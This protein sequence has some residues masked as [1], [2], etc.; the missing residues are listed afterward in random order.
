MSKSICI[1]IVFSV[2]CCCL[3]AGNPLQEKLP[4]PNQI[5]VI[6]SG[7][8]SNNPLLYPEKSKPYALKPITPQ[9]GG[10]N[11]AAGG[12]D[13]FG[14]TYKD[15]NESGGPA[16]NWEDISLT[17]N[18][19]SFVGGSDDGLSDAISIGFSFSYYGNTYTTFKVSS[20]GF[21]TVG[22]DNTDNAYNN[23][24]LPN[25]S[26]PFNILAPFWDD[27]ISNNVRYE[28]LPGRTVISWLNSTRWN[29]GSSTYT[30]QV[31]IYN[32]GK[33]RFNYNQ[34]G[35]TLTSC[36]VGMQNYNGTDGLQVIWNDFYLSNSLCVEFQYPQHMFLTSPNGGE[37]WTA[38]TQ[39]YITWTYAAD[40]VCVLSYSTDNGLNWI[41]IDQGNDMSPLSSPYLWTVPSISTSTQ[42]LI[43]IANC[44]VSESDISDNVFTIT[45]IHLTSPNGGE[46]WTAGTQH[47]ITWTAP[48]D[49]VAYLDY[50]VDN[51]V[52][53]TEIDYGGAPPTGLTSPYS[54]TI[55]SISTSTQCLI[56]IANYGGSESD[57]SDNVF[58][59]TGMQL[60]SPNGGENWT[61][62][63]QHNITWTAPCDPVAYL[64]Y[65]VDNGVSWTEID[66]GGAP[67]TGL[68]SPY[69][70]TIPSISTSTQCLIRI[71]NYGG[72]ESDI[73]DN[74]F[75]I[76]GMHLTS[77]DG[78]ENWTAGTQHNITWTAPGDHVCNLAYSTDNGSNWTNIEQTNDLIPLSSPYLWTVPGISTSIQC[79]IR[80]ASYGGTEVDISDNVFTITGMHLTSPDGG[81]NWT[82]GT[83]HNITWTAPFDPVCYLAY[84]TDI[85][86]S[87][88]I[89]EETNDLN[90]LS[91]P[92][93]WTLPWIS[94]S[95]QCLIRIASYG[96]T[97]S[98]ISDNVFTITGMQLTSP[99]GGE[100]WTAGTQHNIIW[101]APCDPVAYLDYSVDNGMSWTEID[102]GG[103]PPTGLTS[104][105]LWTIPGFIASNQCLI[106][107]A[108]YGGTETDICNN[109]FTISA[110]PTISLTYPNGGETIYVTSSQ[111]INWNVSNGAV[112]NRIELTINGGT[113][114]ATLIE[115]PT[116]LTPTWT[117]TVGNTPSSNC[118]IR[119][120]NTDRSVYN[121]P[122]N[123][124]TILP[125]PLYLSYPN[126]GDL[127]YA[128][129]QIQINFSNSLPQ[130]TVLSYSTDN[131]AGWTY[132]TTTTQGTS[133]L[134]WTVPDVQSDQCLI[135]VAGAID[136]SLKDVSDTPFSIWNTGIKVLTPNGG[137]TWEAGTQH[138]LRY[139]LADTSRTLLLIHLYYSYDNGVNW[140]NY[141]GDIWNLPGIQT[142]DWFVPNIP[143]TTVKYKITMGELSD[144]SDNFFTI[145]PPSLPLI[146]ITAPNG[147]ETLTPGS[148]VDITWSHRLHEDC[149]VLALSYSTNNGTSWTQI[150]TSVQLYDTH[151]LWTVPNVQSENCLIKLEINQSCLNYLDVSDAVFT[152]TNNPFIS[153]T[154][155]NGGETLYASSWRNITWNTYNGAVVSRI[156][157]T[158]DGGTNWTN[159]LESTS[160]IVSPC[161]WC[162]DNTPS[163]NC[164][165]RLSNTYRTV[166][167]VSDSPFTIAPKPLHVISPD[168][169]ELYYAGQ[170]ITIQFSNALAMGTTV[171]YSVNSGSSFTLIDNVG[172]G[173]SQLLWTVPNVQCD[174]CFIRVGDAIDAS[175]YDDS[176]APFSIWNTG[177]K[178]LTPSGGEQW[179]AGTVQ[180][181]S[182]LSAEPNIYTVE[183]FYSLDDG[184]TWTYTAG[185]IDISFRGIFTGITLVPNT[186]SST[187]MVKAVDPRFGSSTCSNYITILPPSLPLVT[188]TYP[189]GGEIF[190]P[191]SQIDIIWTHHLIGLHSVLNLYYS[192]NNGTTWTQIATNI[193]QTA[194]HY[195]WTVPDIQSDNCLIKL[196]AANDPY[197]ND[198]SDAAFSI[199]N[200]GVRVL[201]PNGG[202]SWEAG[203]IQ[204]V[205]YFMATLD[206]Q[207]HLV[208][209]SYSFDGGT[210]FA[211]LIDDLG[212]QGPNELPTWIVPDTPTTMGKLKVTLG[213]F[214]DASDN[215]FT[216][217]PSTLPLITIT[218]PNGGEVLTP[219]SPVNIAW[220]HNL[221]TIID[222]LNLYYSTNNGVN[223]TYIDNVLKNSSPYVWTVPNVNSGQCLVKAEV[224]AEKSICDVSDSVF[225]IGT[226]TPPDAPTDLSIAIDN[227]T[228]DVTLTWT[229]ATGN[230]TG[231]K[232]YRSIDPTFPPESTDVIDITTPSQTSYID[233][234]AAGNVYRYF[235]RITAVK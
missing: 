210:S 31:I 43:L 60:T 143:C 160:P 51:G 126:G 229:A 64:D 223:W 49:P 42:C 103:A 151:Y 19:V 71:A 201:S 114:W 214:S 58:T 124:F 217:V 47:N 165:I 235:Y 129:Q 37:D 233:I 159:I 232:L 231:Y 40:P 119:L 62:G 216:I 111:D 50:S 115:S 26:A 2:L 82:A 208:Q 1:F 70:W 28:Y 187:V 213:E 205:Q 184:L 146:T 17:G 135:R 68:T 137:E 207:P 230:P 203:S 85:G 25:T 91:S 152:I 162:V 166:I 145:T 194:T 138:Q 142:M 134:L 14:Y 228:G 198:V 52:S 34:M 65:S 32:D 12:P 45:G 87:W 153:L 102:Y 98:D 130:G 122:V 61:A 197:S 215:F 164:K 226:P 139:F 30:F 202:E 94:T 186:P 72:S 196:G 59:I 110:P 11:R 182:I 104:P 39:H 222:S 200:S 185:G 106:R 83:Q 41:N 161:S 167:D 55:P 57:I 100:N 105:Y 155:P 168:G 156:E 23:L 123:T 8:I 220:T 117:W 183:I 46:N 173:V 79:L 5:K 84:S 150:S 177:Y 128:G 120:S 171:S 174:E 78:G 188:V 73:S 96:G 33:I 163:S 63:T 209:I 22:S 127:F 172:Q 48:C 6:T 97:E 38:G 56:R 199:M 211:H 27:L 24:Y 81:E 234:G 227:E 86:M 74:V 69:S 221:N 219:G 190:T 21:L 108:N 53:W 179:E 225:T 154:Y 180:Q 218:A 121:N 9:S 77:P 206:E 54:W 92:Y 90:P 131:G 16:Y 88:T 170:Q 76:T 10:V 89:I 118:K 4:S 13:S 109:V 113:S 149:G 20:N 116:P 169:G 158:T 125:N 44:G 140:V 95:A 191:G 36:T 7:P 136:G 3:I 15:N 112:V 195:L 193:P 133:F 35:I 192:T 80:I 181:V 99:N 178:L 107:I 75:T 141:G 189:N 144:T 93:L 67:P 66:Y 101:T 224:N 148:Q 204:H 176:D 132:I 212:D 18:P 157:L 29:D 175:L 147:G